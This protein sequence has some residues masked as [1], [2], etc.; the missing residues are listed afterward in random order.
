MHSK[1]IYEIFKKKILNLNES[2]Y[3]LGIYEQMCCKERYIFIL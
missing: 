3:L 2:I 1:F